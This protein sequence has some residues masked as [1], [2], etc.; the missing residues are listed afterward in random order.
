MNRTPERVGSCVCRYSCALLFHTGTTYISS[1]VYFPRLVELKTVQSC[2][3]FPF[4]LLLFSP[5]APWPFGWFRIRVDNP[6]KESI[7]SPLFHPSTFHTYFHHCMWVYLIMVRF[8]S[9]SYFTPTIVDRISAAFICI[10]LLGVALRYCWFGKLLPICLVAWPCST[11]LVTRRSLTAILK[12][13]SR[14]Q[15]PI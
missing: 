13:T 11:I 9:R 4:A 14:C 10:T 7:A 1:T 15:R 12:T 5:R 3:P 2:R 6:S 8:F